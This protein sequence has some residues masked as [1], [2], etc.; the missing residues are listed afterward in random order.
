MK[1]GLFIL[2]AAL[3]A[4]MLT[5]CIG[6]PLTVDAKTIIDNGDFRYKISDEDDT[7]EIISFRG[8]SLFLSLPSVVDEYTVTSV[9]PAAFRGNKTVKGLE[10]PSSIKK[11]DSC[12]FQ[13]CT[14]LEKIQIP[15]NISEIGDSAFSGCTSLTEVIVDDGLQTI[16]RYSFSD[17]T[18][19]DNIR[20]PNSLDVIG[21]YAFINCTSLSSPEIPKSLRYFGG[22]ALENTEW[23]N[24]QKSEFVVVGDG[25]LIKYTG[26]DKVKS[27]DKSIKKIGSHAFA[28]N[29]NIEEIIIPSSVSIIDV[30]AFEDCESLK[31]MTIPTSVEKIGAKAFKDCI[32]LKTL[33]LPNSINTLETSLFENSGLENIKLPVTIA[34]INERC[35]LNC[36][37]L[38]EIDFGT[39]LKTIKG[40]AFSKCS[41]LKRVVF[42]ASVKEIEK[43]A[44]ESCDGLV[45]AEFNGAIKL[46]SSSFNECPNLKAAVFYANPSELEDNSFNMTP[47]LVIY[48]DNNLYLQQYGESNGKPVDS[49]RNLPAYDPNESLDG[50]EDNGGSGFSLGYAFITI[51]IILIDLGLVILTSIYL[52][53]IEPKQRMKKRDKA[54]AQAAKIRREKAVQ[55]AMNNSE[56]KPVVQPKNV[57]QQKTA[58]RPTVSRGNA[59]KTKEY[60]RPKRNNPDDTKK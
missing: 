53:F 1:K 11:I 36:E 32:S 56:G 2:T 46:F 49:V 29:N 50:T 5:F 27:L 60:R 8:Q 30:S 37:K 42:P 48:C 41:Q 13:G 10:F 52:L 54:L 28:G 14:A 20:L 35:F 34:S 9:G 31:K 16:G 22:Y 6:S 12:A 3:T 24:Q 47:K 17:C 45:R 19:L 59:E 15:G 55:A 7:A 21:D 58:D 26:E 40:F 43:N 23:M 57:T 39:S 44:F 33:N 18:S 4:G 51:L 38:K 25:I